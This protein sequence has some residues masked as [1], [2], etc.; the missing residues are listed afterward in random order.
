MLNSGCLLTF[1]DPV[2]LNADDIVHYGFAGMC[3]ASLDSNREFNP[4]AQGENNLK[5]ILCPPDRRLNPLDDP[6]VPQE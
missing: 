4:V 6:L 5:D 2:D 3:F 1:S